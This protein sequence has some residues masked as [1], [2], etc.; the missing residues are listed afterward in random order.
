MITSVLVT[1]AFMMMSAYMVPPLPFPFISSM[2]C[3]A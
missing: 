1:P 3:I 2:P